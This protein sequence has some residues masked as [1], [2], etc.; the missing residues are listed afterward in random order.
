MTCTDL[1]V[2]LCDYVDGTLSAASQ[3]TVEHHLGECAD[4]RRLAAD[5]KAAV[6]FIEKVADVEPPASLVN[7][8]LFQA[9]VKAAPARRSIKSRIGRWLEPVLQPRFAMG[10]AMT[11]LSFSMLGRFAG[12]PARQLKPSD[13]EPVKIWAALDDKM[14]RS[15]QRAVQ[16]YESIRLVYEIQSTLKDW[17]EPADVQGK[18]GVSSPGSDGKATPVE[19]PI[20]KTP[21]RTPASGAE[22]RVTR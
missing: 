10:M 17:T 16:Y 11:I 3:T 12:I 15:W 8:L 19:G 13:L 9:R 6:S 2:L 20:E 21:A 14:H 1:E 4:C 7:D 5:A 22:G 18:G